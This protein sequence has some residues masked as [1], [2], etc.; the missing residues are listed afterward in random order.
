M[1]VADPLEVAAVV[2]FTIG[3]TACAYFGLHHLQDLLRREPLVPP[4]VALVWTL[5]IVSVIGA[6]VATQSNPSDGLFTASSWFSGG[7]KNNVSLFR[8][9][10]D[11]WYKYELT[12]M[13]QVVR[14]L[15]G[16]MISNFYRPYMVTQVQTK[17]VVCSKRRIYLILG[18]QF[19]VNMFGF[20]S[21]LTDTY[22][23]LSTVDFTAITL[24][25]TTISDCLSTVY[26]CSVDPTAE[27][28]AA[29][30]KD[31]G[32]SLSEPRGPPPGRSA[33]AD[34]R[35]GTTRRPFGLKII[36]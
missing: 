12:V 17:R 22:L 18:G 20:F 2:C 6:T 24:A 29:I 34:T 3:F 4:Y 13:Y 1:G 10:I 21:S 9:R 36:S 7:W 15:I 11:T 25:I 28:C 31:W 5:S 35:V 14:S 26:L 16:S 27:T 8:I 32:P 23:L 33:L 30:G 19:A